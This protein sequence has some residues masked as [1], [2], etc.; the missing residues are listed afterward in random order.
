MLVRRWAASYQKGKF[1][2]PSRTMKYRRFAGLLVAVLFGGLV[3][4]PLA[5]ASGDPRKATE[6]TLDEL[7]HDP[8][9]KALTEDAVKRARAAMERA[10]RMRAAGDEVHALLLDGLAQY[11]AEAGKDLVRAAAAEKQSATARRDATDAGA[12]AER[13]RALLEEGIAQNGRL[14]AQVDAVE[15]ESKQ[16]PTRTAAIGGGGSAAD[17]G[18]PATRSKLD[19]GSPRKALQPPEAPK[20]ELRRDGGSQ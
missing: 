13:E 3:A 10:T 17:G 7:E 12:H 1:G 14:R 20:R 15:R 19:G 16:A 4:M 18:A 5:I 6:T 2:K 11:W 8:A 9:Q